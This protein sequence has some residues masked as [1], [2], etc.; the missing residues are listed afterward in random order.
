M[1]KVYSHPKT[2][3][4]KSS[5]PVNN[6]MKRVVVSNC[7]TMTTKC[8]TNSYMH[9]VGRQFHSW[10]TLGNCQC[11]GNI[12]KFISGNGGINISACVTKYTGISGIGPGACHPSLGAYAS[13]YWQ[14]TNDTNNNGHV[15]STGNIYPTSNC[16]GDMCQYFDALFNL[17]PH[18]QSTF[19]LQFSAEC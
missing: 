5:I 7:S 2:V 3:N 17:N 12:K 11:V 13:A 1:E 15:R 4:Q 16:S 8:I 10:P 14:Q 19:N 6:K 9:I 18:N